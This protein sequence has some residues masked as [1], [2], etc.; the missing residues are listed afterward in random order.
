MHLSSVLLAIASTSTLVSASA[1]YVVQWN[2]SKSYGPDGPWPVV[3]VQV[4]TR[5]NGDGL[6]AVDLHPG[7]IWESMILTEAFCNG[8]DDP[9]HCPA[10]KAG[11]YNINGSH[12]V[13]K[14]ITKEVGLVW[15]W[16]SNSA[17][18]INGSANNV[19]DVMRMGGVQGQS[20]TVGNSTISAVDSSTITLPDGT[21]YSI[22]V[23]TLS[24][25]APGG[26]V[27]PF[28]A[29]VDG[30][31]FAGHAASTNS[32]PSNSFGL[33]YGSSSMNQVGSLVWGGYD[34]SRVIGDAAAFDLTTGN[35]MRPSLLDIQIGV[36]NGSSPFA[37][38]SS[39]MTGLLKQNASF[40]R[41]QPTIINP[42]VPYFFL[43]PQTCT[44]IAANLPVTLEPNIGL[45][46]WNTKDPDYQRIVQ[47]PAYLA[48]IFQNAGAGNLTIKV[49]FPLLNLTLEGPIVATPQ[50]YFPC[51]PFH[52]SDDSGDY[53]LGKAFLQA[54]FIGMN[55][56]QNKFFMAQAPGPGVG[57]SNVQSIGPN[58]TSIN[59]DP[60]E[61]FAITWAKDWTVLCATSN[62][63]PG[64][65][66]ISN[67][68]GPSLSAG[69]KA[70]IGA[71]AAVGVLVA[72]VAL[73]LFCIQ[74][75]KN[76]VGRVV[77][78]QGGETLEPE[79]E[80]MYRPL[81]E[82]DVRPVSYETGLASP[83]E[84]GTEQPVRYPLELG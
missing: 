50:P 19:V 79:P 29:G 68:S 2:S 8:D 13:L 10:A 15:Q 38:G 72:I 23:G 33:H 55:W 35:E 7:G 75:R 12:N 76:R 9:T 4:G 70:G 1:P 66:T 60:V 84:M 83:H 53:V 45:Y 17:F 48:F 36:E 39:S 77:R 31:T 30:E 28:E 42:I 59:S 25:G 46:L 24:L 78:R 57:A 74:R 49:P 69:A 37:S 18:N 62:S 3:T 80:P 22:Q 27:Q 64:N 52:A 40:G 26:G 41:A 32:I 51:R 63:T 44:T 14:N 6:S 61:H 82:K 58:H 21:N 73:S 34:Q 67:G 5:A 16:G 54:A 81:H 11:L 47:S 20:M 56:E 71:G 65:G 43:S